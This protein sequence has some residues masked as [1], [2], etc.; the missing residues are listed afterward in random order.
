MQ[1]GMAKKTFFSRRPG[2]GTVPELCMNMFSPAGV[3]KKGACV[4]Y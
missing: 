1:E 3:C 4:L 2:R